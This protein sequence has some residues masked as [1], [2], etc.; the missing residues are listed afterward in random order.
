MLIIIIVTTTKYP[1]QKV[2][3]QRLRSCIF[4]YLYTFKKY[5]LKFY[6][7]FLIHNIRQNLMFFILSAFDQPFLATIYNHQCSISIKQL[8][9]INLLLLAYYILYIHDFCA[10]A[11]IE[12]TLC[13]Y[14]KQISHSNAIRHLPI[15]SSSAN[16]N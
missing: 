6:N 11:S 3:T 9:L 2:L 5:F 7:K 12:W 8:V 1:K 10:S 15:E 13:V 14:D 16:C 4:L